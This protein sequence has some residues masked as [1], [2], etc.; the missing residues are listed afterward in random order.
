MSE[1]QNIEHIIVDGHSHVYK[2]HVADKI[3]GSFTNFYRIMPV[4]VGKGTVSDM[5]HNMDLSEEDKSK[6]LGGNGLT[7]YRK[8]FNTN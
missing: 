4:A 6:I 2:D 8:G 7:L 5:L 1:R 3:I